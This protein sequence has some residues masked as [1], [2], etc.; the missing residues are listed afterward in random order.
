MLLTTSCQKTDLR[1]NCDEENE[2][3]IGTL[4]AKEFENISCRL[5]NIEN[6]KKEVN[7]V[8]TNQ[9]DFAKYIS[10]SGQLPFIDFEK[11]FILFGPYKHHQCAVFHAHQFAVCNNRTIYNVKLLEQDCWAFTTVYYATVIEK[12][13]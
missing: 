13:H 6:E 4:Y 9:K 1:Q 11:Y 8:I 5:Q 12:I 3:N 2:Q 10:C 7:L